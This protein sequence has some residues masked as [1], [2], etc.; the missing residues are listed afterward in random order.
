M[1]KSIFIISLILSFGLFASDNWVGKKAPYFDLP[2]QSGVFHNLNDYKGKWLV[3]YFYPKDDTPGCTTEAQNFTKDYDSFKQ[4]GAEIVGASLDD[5]ESHKEFADKYSIPFTLLADKDEVMASA[6]GVIKKVP[7][8]HYAKRQTFIITPTGFVAKFYEDV[9][10]STH[11]Q[12][13][14]NDLKDIIKNT[15]HSI[16]EDGFEKE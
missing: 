15:K 2:D 7:L 1:K 14:L 13:V 12:E 8:M 11:S 10:A 5:I 16:S 9:K 4:L 3:L 6:Y